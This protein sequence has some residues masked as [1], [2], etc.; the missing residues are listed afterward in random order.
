[1]SSGL[2]S[3][4]SGLTIGQGLYRVVSSLW[5]G[6]AGFVT[7]WDAAPTGVSYLTLEDGSGSLLL[8]SGDFLLLESSS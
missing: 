1:M 2:F 8:E 4:K 5:S 6:A 7:D 3:G